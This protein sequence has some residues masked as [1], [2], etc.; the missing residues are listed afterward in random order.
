MG[1]PVMFEYR[2]PPEI[3]GTTREQ[4]ALIMQLW[5]KDYQLDIGDYPETLAIVLH[6]AGATFVD[7]SQ[8]F[9]SES[10]F[11]NVS[12]A[13]NSGAVEKRDARGFDFAALN[14][15]RKGRRL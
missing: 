3:D 11:A 4:R 8:E 13:I 7:R 1:E 10:L 14:A 2:D 5:M 9:P 6:V 15:L 12:L